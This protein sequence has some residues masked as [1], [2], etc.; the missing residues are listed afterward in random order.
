M[1]IRELKSKARLI[2]PTI[3]IGKNGLTDNQIAEI[4]KQLKTRKLVKIKF[5]KSFFE[6]QDVREAVKTILD[7]SG[8]ILVSFVGNVVSIYKQ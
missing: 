7:N 5:L 3:R 1:D 6:N 8:A 4:K 2:E